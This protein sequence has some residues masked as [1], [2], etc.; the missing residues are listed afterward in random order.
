MLEAYGLDRSIRYVYLP[1]GDESPKDTSG[2]TA[3]QARDM[4][5]AGV[6]KC[7]DPA[8][9][10]TL[11]FVGPSEVK[12]AFWR[13]SKGFADCSVSQGGEGAWHIRVKNLCF[14]NAADFE[15]KITAP[16]GSTARLDVFVER[17]RD[18]YAVEVQHSPIDMATLSSRIAV[19]RAAGLKGTVWVVDAAQAGISDR[20]LRFLFGDAAGSTGR[21]SKGHDMKDLRR[22][23]G[24]EPLSITSPWVSDLIR[25]AEQMQYE[26]HTTSIV[27]LG[28]NNSGEF[29]GRRIMEVTPFSGSNAA[30][31]HI[32]QVSKSHI[33]QANFRSWSV[34]DESSAK[35]NL[36]LSRKIAHRPYR[37]A[38]YHFAI[39]LV[40]VYL[41]TPRG[42]I[43]QEITNPTN[44]RAFVPLKE[45]CEC[46]DCDYRARRGLDLC[47]ARV[48]FA[49]ADHPLTVPDMLKV[50]KR[51]KG[52]REKFTF[53]MLPCDLFL[54]CRN[55]SYARHMIEFGRK[56]KQ[57]GINVDGHN[58]FSHELDYGYDE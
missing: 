8:C 50:L 40:G 4:A 12:Q 18:Q 22:G 54:R 57:A 46:D 48:W 49:D 6:L 34:N 43:P 15:H 21:T 29:V 13:H 1:D 24:G 27:L 19:H 16:D 58:E 55:K 37:N 25:Y 36:A 47:H 23:Y 44:K 35:L 39:G 11:H 52:R 30:G 20:D 28:V 26:E 2:L 7:P 17:G 14:G 9:S 51:A 42:A 3:P 56:L 53:S 33:K 41:L 10:A 31:H 45:P 5:R 38:T 32:F